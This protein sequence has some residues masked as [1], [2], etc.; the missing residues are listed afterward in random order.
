AG[1]AVR[2]GHGHGPLNHGFAPVAQQ[3][4]QGGA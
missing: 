3:I 4:L 1:A 2:T